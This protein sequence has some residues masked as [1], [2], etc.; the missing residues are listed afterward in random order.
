MEQHGIVC[1]AATHGQRLTQE[2]V[3]RG[4]AQLSFAQLELPNEERL[5]SGVAQY[6]A[7]NPAQLSSMPRSAWS[8]PWCAQSGAQYGAQVGGVPSVAIKVLWVGE[9]RA[10]LGVRVWPKRQAATVSS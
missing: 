10:W 8:A 4:V 2:E 3:A 1:V 6:G 9:G 5:N 7:R